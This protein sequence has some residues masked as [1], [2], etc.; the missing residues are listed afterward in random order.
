MMVKRECVDI[1]GLQGTTPLHIASRY[2]HTKAVE[3]LLKRGADLTETCVIL[4]NN[5]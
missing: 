1:K 2:N 3:V 5:Q 4:I